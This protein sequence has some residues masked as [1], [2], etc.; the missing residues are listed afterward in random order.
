MQAVPRAENS[1]GLLDPFTTL[2]G[3][4]AALTQAPVGTADCSLISPDQFEALRNH[5][6]FRAPLERFARARMVAEAKGLT[7]KQVARLTV[8][9]EGRLALLLLLESAER[10]GQAALLV[11][12]AAMYA[13]ALRIVHK[14]K[15]ERLREALG[16]AA[17]QVAAL[18]AP[19]LYPSL[20]AFGSDR[21]MDEALEETPDAAR[22]KFTD[23]GFL[24]L[25]SVVAVHFQPLAKLAVARWSW[26]E[27]SGRRFRKLSNQDLQHILL[28]LQR[29]LPEW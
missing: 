17:Y 15:R 16:E 23:L 13:Q 9:S 1:A 8:S 2:V 28:L 4:A 22:K 11:C 6:A 19:M 25:A 12:G 21:L 18:E 7:R 3:L 29:R 5:S 14:E 26:G 27:T 20:S 24:L 10:V